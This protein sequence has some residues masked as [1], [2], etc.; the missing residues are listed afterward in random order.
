MSVDEDKRTV[1]TVTLHTITWFLTT[2]LSLTGNSLICVA[3]YNNRRLLTITNF[4]VLSLTLIDLIAASFGYPFN[5]ISSGL[6]RWPFG[7]NFCQFNGFLSHFWTVA[8][9]H[10]LALTAMN[11]YFCIIKPRFYSILFTRE[12]ENGS[13]YHIGVAVHPYRGFSSYLC[14]ASGIPVASLLFILPNWK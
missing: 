10:M 12:K 8:S 13:F 7:H 6:R 11:R 1:T 9:I 14:H 3:F 5:T 4:F 2:L